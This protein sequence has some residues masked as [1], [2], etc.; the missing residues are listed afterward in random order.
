MHS[1]VLTKNNVVDGD[2]YEFNEVPNG[3]HDSK[4]NSTAGCD[5]NVFFII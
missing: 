4:T 2:E 3:A 1:S 5:F